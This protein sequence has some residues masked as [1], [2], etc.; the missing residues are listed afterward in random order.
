[1]NFIINKEEFLQVVAAWK[2]IPG[3]DA[4]DHIFYNALRGHDLKR[5]FVPIKSEIKLANGA[6]PWQSYEAAI[7]DASWQLRD[8]PTYANTPE[9]KAK[10]EAEY[11]NRIESLSKRFGITFTP[12]LIAKLKESFK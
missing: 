1:M 8:A 4:T 12:E 6:A 10:N 2:Q 5:G 9:R 7:K 3:H 11:K